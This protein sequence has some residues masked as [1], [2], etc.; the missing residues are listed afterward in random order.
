VTAAGRPDASTGAFVADRRGNRLAD[1]EIRSH[2]GGH[3]ILL[4]GPT[5]VA[6]QLTAVRSHNYHLYHLQLAENMDRTR[7]THRLIATGAVDPSIVDLLTLL[8]NVLTVPAPTGVNVVIALDWYKLRTEDVDPSDWPNTHTGELVSRGKY[9]FKHNPEL[10]SAIGRTLVRAMVSVVE[11]HPT[12]NAADLVVVVPGHDRARVSFGARLAVSVAARRG[13]GHVKLY[14]RQQF[15]PAAKAMEPR[16]RT[17]A[18][19]GEFGTDADLE[20]KNVIVAD[21]VYQSGATMREAA[22]AARVAGADTV[23]GLAAVRTIRS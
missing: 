7:W 1:Y 23:L 18:L 21:D 5:E 4:R 6:R 11:R 19:R 10:Q 16:E 14:S 3:E 13:I 22:R 9:Y 8:Q 20:G 2:N 15:R 17:R 12:Y